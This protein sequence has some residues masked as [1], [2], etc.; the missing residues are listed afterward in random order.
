MVNN[1]KAITMGPDTWNDGRSKSRVANYTAFWDKDAVHDGSEQKANRV[2][3]YKDVI[4]GIPSSIA[5]VLYRTNQLFR[6][7]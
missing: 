6:L 2:E 1:S 7:L 3:N 4:N 5:V